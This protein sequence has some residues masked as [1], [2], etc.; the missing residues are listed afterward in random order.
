MDESSTFL[1]FV[2]KVSY[3]VFSVG[4]SLRCGDSGIL[5]AMVIGLFV[6]LP[7]G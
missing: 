3:I 6:G 1:P 5:R 2:S 4:F 7:R